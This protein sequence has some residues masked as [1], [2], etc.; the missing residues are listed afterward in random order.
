[1]FFVCTGSDLVEAEKT[2]IKIVESPYVLYFKDVPKYFKPG[3]PFDLTVRTIICF[4]SI[5]TWIWIFALVCLTATKFKHQTS[6][7]VFVLFSLI[8]KFPPTSPDPGEPARR[9]PG[10]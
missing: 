9:D 3:L 7:W 10:P 2:G 1:M 4:Y 6:S 8:Q 5:S